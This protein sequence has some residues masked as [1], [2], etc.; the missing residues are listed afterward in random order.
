MGQ[1]TVSHT[2]NESNDVQVLRPL[3]VL[4]EEWLKLRQQGVP[5]PAIAIWQNLQDPAGNLWREYVNGAYT[6]PACELPH[7]AKQ[8]LPYPLLTLLA[9]GEQT[10]ISSSRTRSRGAR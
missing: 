6:D 10:M 5:T 7:T 3:E 8:L 4:A 1:T 2:P 9:G